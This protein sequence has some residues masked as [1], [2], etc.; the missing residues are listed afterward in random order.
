MKFYGVEMKGKF[1]NHI[2]PTVPAFD[3]AEDGGRLIYVEADGLLW[4]GDADSGTPGWKALGTP[5]EAV[6]GAIDVNQYT[7]PSPRASVSI[8]YTPGELLVL[9][10]GISLATTD[11][12]ATNGTSITFPAPQLQTGDVVQVVSVVD[13]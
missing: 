4:W 7:V 13:A 12:T 10:N 5:N 6:G 11:Y 3:I 9:L 8:T 1:T 2:L